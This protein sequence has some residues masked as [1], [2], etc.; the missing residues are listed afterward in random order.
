MEFEAY[1]DYEQNERVIKWLRENGLS[2]VVG[3][4][5]G[6]VGI[7][8]WQQWRSHQA[9]TQAEASQLYQQMQVAQASN[10]PE[11]ATKLVDELMKDYSKSPYAV[12]AANDRARQQVHAGELD[13][14]AVSLDWAAAHVADTAL[15]P[16]IQLRVARLQLARDQGAAALATLDS[17]PA[18]SFSGMTQE[19]RGDVLVKLGRLDDARK[20]YQAAMSALSSEA[21]QRGVLQMKLDDLAVAGKQGA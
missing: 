11:V 16:L 9:R 17:I 2:I 4:I 5:I 18:T 6:L 15:K 14:A 19:L 3:I 10:Q 12:F 7:F 20:A 8:G 21:P 13:K 1:D